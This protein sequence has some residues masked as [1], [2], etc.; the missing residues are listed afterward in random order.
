MKESDRSRPHAHHA[1]AGNSASNS[2]GSL[3]G[4][5]ADGMRS[6]L[7]NSGEAL[8]GRE[9]AGHWRE[10][11]LAERALGWV[12]WTALALVIVLVSG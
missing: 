3:P 6:D 12:L 10:A 4:P 2:V 9:L 5:H 11:I 1:L 7:R 8:L